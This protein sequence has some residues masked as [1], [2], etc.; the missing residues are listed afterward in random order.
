ME[1]LKTRQT[2]AQGS[3]QEFADKVEG[4][5][6]QLVHPVTITAPI[7]YADEA[8]V[9]E[10]PAFES[11]GIQPEPTIYLENRGNEAGLD[12]N[13][14]QVGS[15]WG[16]STETLPLPKTP[17]TPI[18]SKPRNITPVGVTQGGTWM[19]FRKSSS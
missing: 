16:S 1:N 18:K 10:Q 12:N 13:L 9:G 7:Y 19:V 4:K 14:D 3:F 5:L 2:L 6:N 15:P 17:D 8:Q 11:L